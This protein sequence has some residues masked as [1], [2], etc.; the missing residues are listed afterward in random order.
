MQET[1]IPSKGKQADVVSHQS[2]TCLAGTDRC[3]F[4]VEAEIA[5][6]EIDVILV[7]IPIKR[8]ERHLR[9]RWSAQHRG[10]QK[11]SRGRSTNVRKPHLNSPSRVRKKTKRFPW[12]S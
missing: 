4:E 2:E 5:L 12:R 1:M 6:D 7:P 11:C 10:R 3:F 9:Q 8:I